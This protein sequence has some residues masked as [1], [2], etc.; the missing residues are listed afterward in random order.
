MKGL[1]CQWTTIRGKHINKQLETSQYFQTNFY[2]FVNL[3]IFIFY[4]WSHNN[5]QQIEGQACPKLFI[6]NFGSPDIPLGLRFEIW[7]NSI[8][9]ACCSL[10]LSPESTNISKLL[11]SKLTRFPQKKVKKKRKKTKEN[12][13][14]I[15][16]T[17]DY[18]HARLGQELGC[19]KVGTTKR[20]I[21]DKIPNEPGPIIV[22]EDVY[23]ACS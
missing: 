15:A 3:W 14:F 17:V 18:L 20:L 8:L 1:Y 22:L 4:F 21:I 23:Y 9:D 7:F 12:R 6:C 16:H 11:S 2:C 13:N 10:L 5:P 19:L